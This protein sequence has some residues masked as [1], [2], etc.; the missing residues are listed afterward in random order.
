MPRKTCPV[1]SHSLVKLFVYMGLFF[2]RD[3][4]SFKKNSLNENQLLITKSLLEVQSVVPPEGEYLLLLDSPTIIIACRDNANISVNLDVTLD[5]EMRRQPLIM[6]SYEESVGF[7]SGFP[8]VQSHFVLVRA[9]NS[10]ESE[11]KNSYAAYIAHIRLVRKIHKYI[12]CFIC[13][14]L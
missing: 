7:L 1:T 8:Q 11:F 4:S 14:T 2:V 6:I 9:S 3:G 5:D 10:L 12:V 13:I